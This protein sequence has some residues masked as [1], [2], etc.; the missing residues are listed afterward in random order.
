MPGMPED[1]VRDFVFI[2]DRSANRGLKSK[3]SGPRRDEEAIQQ[4]KADYFFNLPGLRIKA[5]TKIMVEGRGTAA[6]DNI[7]TRS[8]EWLKNFID[9]NA[10][11]QAM[12]EYREAL[13]AVNK[14]MEALSEEMKNKEISMLNIGEGEE[15]FKEDV[16]DFD[17]Y[18]S[19]ELY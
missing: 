10:A 19:F 6:V 15:E 13:S 1:I 11:T 2:F 3:D 12:R 5:F 16:E 17:G 7:Y 18:E 8:P 9:L 14:R 4:D